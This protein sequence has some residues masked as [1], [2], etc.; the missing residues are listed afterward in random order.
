MRIVALLS[1]LLVTVFCRGGVFDTVKLLPVSA[2]MVRVQDIYNNQVKQKDSFFAINSI[3]QLIAIAR[4]LDDKPLRCFSTSLLADQYARIRSLNDESTQLHKDAISMAQEF[5]LPLMT[6]ICTY[7]MGRYYYSF[8]NYPFAFEYLLRADNYFKSTGY[9]DVPDI[10][11]ILYFMAGIY[12]ETGNNDMAESYLQDIQQLPVIN[13]YIKKQ[14]LN[15]LALINRQQND[16][17][18]AL[19]YFEKTLQVAMAE[20]DSIWIGISYSNIASLYFLQQNY[21]KAY[22]F[23]QQGYR[24]SLKYSEWSHAY[25]CLLYMARIDIFQGNTQAAEKQI[26]AAMA[27]PASNSNMNARRLLYETRVS[28]YEAVRQPVMALQVQSRLIALKDSIAV[29]KDQKAYREILLRIE[30][31]KHLNVIGKLETDKRTDT[32]K[33]NAIIAGLVLILLVLLL[34]YRNYRV[35]SRSTAAILQADKL[36]AE[37][38]LKYARQLLQ[39]FTENTRQKNELI[40]QFTQELERLKASLPGQLLY[41]ERLLNFEKLMQSNILSD[42]EWASF[43]ELFEKVHKGFF[44]RLADKYPGLSVSDTRL[45]SLIR[46]GISDQEISNMMGMTKENVQTSKQLVRSKLQDEGHVEEIIKNI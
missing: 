5:D 24:L 26:N 4:D 27:L 8:K 31:E 1:L 40:I 13:S 19:H 37:E 16:T 38:K 15:T 32:I 33:R 2:R 39:N 10:D 22:S 20:P 18:K 41:E 7:R 17:V 29:S 44:Q 14:S 30:T 42:E 28:Y 9:K 46:L 25:I 21:D 43:K 6:A 35:K 11:E 34:W 23:F 12:Y 36:R 3:R 45:I